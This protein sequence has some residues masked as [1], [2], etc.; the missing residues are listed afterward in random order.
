MNPR[1][2]KEKKEERLFKDIIINNFPNLRKDMDINI[3]EDEQ[4]L[5]SNTKSL[6]PDT[7]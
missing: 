4:T 6:L 7:L 1:R 3:Q 5:R 2:R